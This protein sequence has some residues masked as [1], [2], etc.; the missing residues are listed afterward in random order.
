MKHIW[1]RID[2]TSHQNTESIVRARFKKAINPISL[3]YS[4]NKI[5][6]IKKNSA[7]WDSFVTH[8]GS[9]ITEKKRKNRKKNKQTKT[10]LQN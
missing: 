2:F 6:P 5:I 4:R 9:L 8:Y 3:K 1:K 10:T 7:A